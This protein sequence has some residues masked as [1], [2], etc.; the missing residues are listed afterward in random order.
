MAGYILSPDALH[1]LQDIWDFI[2]FDSASAANQLEDGY[3]MHL[4][5]WLGNRGWGTLAGT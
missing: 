2:A 1:D 5:N 4:R 3:S